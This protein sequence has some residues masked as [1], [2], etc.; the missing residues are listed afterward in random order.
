MERFLSK[1]KN[2]RRVAESGL[3]YY[4]IKKEKLIGERAGP[5]KGGLFITFGKHSTSYPIIPGYSTSFPGI[6]NVSKNNL[7]DKYSYTRL[8]DYGILKAF[9]GCRAGKAVNTFQQNGTL[10]IPV[11][12]QSRRIYIPNSS[13]KTK[14]KFANNFDCYQGV[15]VPVRKIESTPKQSSS[16]LCVP[17]FLLSNV[18]SLLPGHCCQV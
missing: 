7:V 9:R 16:T 17:S 5:N 3:V 13:L 14:S 2:S 12:T 1:H 11:I 4:C 15:L 18:M 6:R 10:N 8:K